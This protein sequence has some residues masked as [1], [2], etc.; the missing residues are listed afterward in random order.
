MSE[1]QE[2]GEVVKINSEKDL[3][4]SEYSNRTSKE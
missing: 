4:F 3:D 2:E 1:E